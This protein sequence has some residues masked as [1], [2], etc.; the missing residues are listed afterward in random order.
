[1][2][3]AMD[4][5]QTESSGLENFI[6]RIRECADKLSNLQKREDILADS[7]R[8]FAEFA[9]AADVLIIDLS[10]ESLDLYRSKERTVDSQTSTVILEESVAPLLE[11]LQ[12]RYLDELGVRIFNKKILDPPEGIEDDHIAEAL[13]QLGMNQGF[14]LP[15][16][17]ARSFG[18]ENVHGIL[19]INTIPSYRFADPAHFALL[20]MAAD[21]LSVTADNRDLG[22]ALARLR[23]TDQVTG[24]ASK[25]K[26]LA[27]LSQEVSRAAY[28]NRSFALIL[29]NIDNFKSLN[30]KQGYRYGDLVIKTVAEDIL[31]EARPI[32]TV[33][34][35][36]GEEYMILM[37]EVSG[38]EAFEFAERCRKKTGEHPIT[39][40]DYREEIFVSL[41]F[42][43]VVYPGHGHNADMLLRNAELALLQSKLNGR[44][45][46]LL[47]SE[48]WLNTK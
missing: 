9:N 22:N 5:E 36:A 48:E 7:A 17:V 41:S 21:L 24:L 26:L 28:L 2:D 4:K 33:C 35:W 8:L 15:L 46:S 1:M 13:E 43:I 18:A 12:D 6:L 40:D 42:G 19:L 37:P 44:N 31:S 10:R 27:Q 29:G 47:W 34:R 25:N 16:T 32:D 45:Q 14:I 23:P 38:E 3:R 11:L 20:R 39:P 30:V